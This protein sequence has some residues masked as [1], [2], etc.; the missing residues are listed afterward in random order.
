M[1][2][3]THPE[4]IVRR[5][6]VAMLVNL[7]NLAAWSLGSYIHPY[8]YAA[9]SLLIALFL[10]R[11]GANGR[12][13]LLFLLVGAVLILG[14]PVTD[15]DARTIWFFHA[16]RIFFD[17]NLY[18]QLDDYAPF[19]H[20]DYP[21]LVPALAASIARGVGYWNEIFPRLSVVAAYVPA[22]LVLV[23]LYPNRVIFNVIVAVVLLIGKE[24][25]FNGYMDAI[26]AI[27]AAVACALLAKIYTQ[28]RNAETAKTKLFD[29]LV[30][31]LSVATLL[32]L[33]NEGLLCA[34]ILLACVLPKVYRQPLPLILS[35]APFLLYFVL[36]KT[37]VTQ[38]HV[39]GDLFVAG[40]ADRIVAR[41]QNA[42]EIG[43]ILKAFAQQSWIFVAALAF[44]VFRSTQLGRLAQFAPSFIFIVV[45]C[46]GILAIYVA[47]PNMLP[48][49]L[50]TSASR[51]FM[52]ANFSILLTCSYLALIDGNLF[53]SKGAA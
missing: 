20:N 9:F 51:V 24:Y 52:T 42:Q 4:A 30:F 29:Y 21:V 28:D 36:W 15:W 37:H 8:A 44:A 33:K 32:H 49:H 35:L 40:M 7:G 11:E 41:L 43:L 47:T 48:W 50:A 22:F 31:S 18:A 5:G 2:A 26:V 3:Q 14:A 45:Y 17:N 6:L 53:R 1:T 12:V 39:H 13:A 25:L 23:W 27:Y 10:I 16:K 34:V 38:H 19:S 46:A